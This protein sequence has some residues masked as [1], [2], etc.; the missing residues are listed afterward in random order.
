M[1][2]VATLFSGIGTPEQS[3]KHLQ[4][5]HETVFACEIDKYAR[6]TYLA[7]NQEPNTFYDDVY[8]IDGNKYKNQID[9]LIGGSP[10]QSFS[11]AGKRKGT[12]CPRG[13][14]IYEYF[15]I[16]EESQPKV[17]I[18]ENVKGFLSIDKGETFKN[19]VQSFKDLGYTTYHQVL[20]T[21]DYGVPQNRERIYIVGFKD[22]VDFHFQEKQELKLRLKDMLEDEV[23]KKYLLNQDLVS[24]YLETGTASNHK[25]SQAGKVADENDE[26]FWTINAGTHGYSMGYIKLKQTHTLNIKACEQIKRIYSADGLCPTLDTMQGGH[27]QPKVAIEKEIIKLFD[28]PKEIL[29]DNERQ[30][31]VYSTEGISPAVIARS[32]S[33]KI[34]VNGLIE[35]SDEVRVKEATKLGYKV[36]EEGDSINI[37]VPSSKTRRGRVGKQVAQTLDTACNQVVFNNQYIFRK[38]T[39]RECF[40][41][42]GFDD[43]F[44][45]PPKMS[46]T[47]LYKQAGNGMSRNILDMIFTQIFISFKRH[48]NNM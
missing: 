14:L 33:A 46:D 26:T 32:D 44:I 48:I 7:N 13:N 5:E 21:K 37:S 19:F 45:F 4:V 28:I 25:G 17:F 20:N 18:Y 9:I 3:L 34:L 43:S 35:V 8:N 11:I 24:K 41:L 15:R 6:T 12:S 39:P 10:C 29:N 47:Q 40:R 38:L 42:Q 1:L 30:R 22:N 16:V 31:R 2:K 23:D 27:R 36:A